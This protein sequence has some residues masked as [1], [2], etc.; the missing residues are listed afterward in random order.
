MSHA[1][2]TRSSYRPGNRVYSSALWL[3]EAILAKGYL[4][5]TTCV[6]GSIASAMDAA[7][8]AMHSDPAELTPWVVYDQVQRDLESLASLRQLTDWN[9]ETSMDPDE[10]GPLWEESRSQGN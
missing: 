3:V 7:G 1:D 4:G 10:L 6:K 8:A 9:A 5:T 2:R